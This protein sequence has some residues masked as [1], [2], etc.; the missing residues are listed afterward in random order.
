MLFVHAIGD[1]VMAHTEGEFNDRNDILVGFDLEFV[2]RMP[3]LLGF[4][5]MAI[6]VRMMSFLFDFLLPSNR[7]R[8][9]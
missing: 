4:F 1:E 5:S 3:E 2:D 9:F 7:I 6:S 8:C